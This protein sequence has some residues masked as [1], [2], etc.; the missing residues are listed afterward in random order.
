MRIDLHSHSTAS[1]GTDP[2]A[3]VMRRAKDAGL[4]VIALTDHDTWAGHEPARAAMPGGLT[5]VPGMELSCQA[6]GHSVHLLAYL[7]DPADPALVR[8]CQAITGDRVHRARAMVGRLAALGVAITWEQVSAI[9]GDGVV[10]RPHIARAM[11]AA[12]AIATTAEAFTEDWIGAGGRA[13]VQRYA[14][15]PGTAVRLVAAAGGVS[16]LAHPGLAQRGWLMPDED[17]AGLAAA[18]LAGLEA[19]HPGHEDAQRWRLRDLAA[20]LGLAVTGG[21]DYHGSFS[22]HG[23]GSATTSPEAF[24]QLMSAAGGTLGPA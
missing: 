17:I 21:S 1:D 12:G 15:A 9:A 7:A 22:S 16:V 11:V 24:E 20:S 5:L 8:E 10:G 14:P 18:G 3:E 4:D 2:P 19:D 13:H 6:Q 23:L